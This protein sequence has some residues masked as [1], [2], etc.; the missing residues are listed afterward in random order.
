MGSYDGAEVC[1]LVG[2]YILHLLKVTGVDLGLYRDDML[3]VTRTRGRSLEKMKQTIQSIFQEAGLKVVGAVGLE[4]TDFLDIFMDLR[5]G[6]F[7]SFVKEGDRPTYVHSQS[8]HPPS[9]LKNIGPGVNKRLSMLNANQELF[10]Q[11]APLYQEA[12]DRGKHTHALSFGQEEPTAPSSRRRRRRDVIWWNPPYSLNMETNIGARFLA[13]IDHCFPK[14]TIMAKVFNR[15]NLKIS[16]RTC[17]NM[18]QILAKHNKKIIAANQPKA[19]VR[20]CN[21]PARKREAGECPLQGK[22]LTKNNVYQATVVETK[23]DGE[24]KVETYVGVCATTWKERYRNH[25]KSFNNPNYKGETILST[26]IWE[27]KARGSTYSI[28]WKV[29]DRGSPFTPITNKC[30]LCTK[31]KFYIL[32]KPEL[33]SLNSRQEVGTHCAH[34][35]MSLL[36]KVAKVKVT[37]PPGTS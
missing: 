18:K 32:R 29:I 17:P 11:A 36:S 26:H 14:G 20:D 8:N 5:A 33:A 10:D 27:L 34:V 23:V 16:Y 24:E 37:Q 28:A 12:L 6:T 31:E 21:C 35:A 13:L 7:R 4:A 15:N 22:C 25:N 3:G 2:L 9:V 30:M 19:E 1:E